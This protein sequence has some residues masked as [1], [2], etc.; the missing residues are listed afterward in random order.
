Q[1]EKGEPYFLYLA[2]PSPHT[3]ILPTGE[4]D[5]KSNFL[6]YAD[7]VMQIDHYIGNLV[8]VVEETG[9]AENT[10]IIFTTDNGCSP[11][12]GY[13][14]MVEMGHLPNLHYRGHKA[15]IYDGGHRVPFIAKWPAQ[16]KAGQVSDQLVCTTDLLATLADILDYDLQANEGEDSYSILP[17][18]KQKEVDNEL[19][20][21]V[22][23]HSVNGS[24]AIRDGDWK[25]ILVPGS[26]GW[27]YPRPGKDQA[28]LD[29]LPP[30]QLYN[31]QD[32]PGETTNIHGEYPEKVLQLKQL[33]AEYIQKGRSTPGPAQ[34]N[35]E[36]EGEWKQIAWMEDLQ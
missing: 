36:F 4:W 34:S 18:L 26:G 31:M 10:L 11:A 35:D 16:I 13:H 7:F 14:K 2:L 27:S 23:H 19:R 20:S 3:P 25:L 30:I 28:V 12:A 22:V 5:G 21:A 17:L 29:T 24:F 15:D 8:K 33:L 1:S 6:P 32:D 9:Q